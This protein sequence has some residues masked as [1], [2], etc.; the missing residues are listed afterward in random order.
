VGGEAEMIYKES[1][2]HNKPCVVEGKKFDSRKEARR[3]GE[4]CFLERA[5]EIRNLK[6][7]VKFELIP[8]QD[9]ERACHYKADFTYYEKD[10]NGEWQYIVEDCKGMRTDVY[11]IKR[12]LMLRIYSIRIRE[13]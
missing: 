4:L 7:Q 13:T 12:K 11:K 3:Y 9:G 8:K 2:Y 1:K 5:G 6:R 10:K